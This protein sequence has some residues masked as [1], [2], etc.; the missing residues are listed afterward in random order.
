MNATDLAGGCAP[1]RF[2]ILEE[3]LNPSTD[4]FVL[5]YLKSIAKEG[6]SIER[7][8][9]RQPLGE[10]I[11]EGDFVVIVRYL[12][13]DWKAAIRKHRPAMS[14]LAYFMDDDIPDVSASRELPLK[15]RF[16]LFYYGA[17][18]FNWLMSQGSTLWVSTLYLKQKYARFQPLQIDPSPIHPP[19]GRIHVFYHATASHAAE[20]AWLY[21]VMK[22]A[23]EADPL[24]D[25][26]MIGDQ[27]TL[28]MYRGLPRTTVVHPMS[29]EAYQGFIARPG[30]HIGL[31]PFI[32]SPFNAARSHTKRFDIER[33]GAI[34]IYADTGP[35]ASSLQ[36]TPSLSA[37]LLPMNPDQW[38]TTILETAKTLR[39]AA[40]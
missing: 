17:R 16:K 11:R 37:K 7:V 18:H 1:R 30:R 38:V 35:W 15:Y 27:K 36:E 10:N 5:P 32:P 13:T 29:W 40:N 28:A 4:Y 33:A 25:F 9:W 8:T 31:A 19:A 22:S 26:E 2:L 6:V 34:G 39:G 20:I 23:L 24:L 14:G 12:T 3:K 21:P